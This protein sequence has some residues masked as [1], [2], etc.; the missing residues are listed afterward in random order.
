MLSYL[1]DT[2]SAQENAQLV[3]ES[4]RKLS[5]ALSSQ[6]QHASSDTDGAQFQDLQNRFIRE[7]G[8]VSVTESTYSELRE[9]LHRRLIVAQDIEA[10]AL[11]S[12]QLSQIQPLVAMCLSRPSRYCNLV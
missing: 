3:I 6:G 1:I 7:V 10:I 12:V 5:T 9:T 2:R 8:V 11:H 4:L